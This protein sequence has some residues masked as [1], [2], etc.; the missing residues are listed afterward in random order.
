MP[1]VRSE[2]AALKAL[3]LSQFTQFEE[4][5]AAMAM[6]EV[7]S[8]Q[9]HPLD[10]VTTLVSRD[11]YHTRAQLVAGLAQMA[12]LVRSPAEH[13]MAEVLSHHTSAALG[14][15]AKA[16]IADVIAQAD[17]MLMH[18]DDIA[19]AID[20]HP[21]RVCHALRL[22][23]HDGIFT[24]VDEGTFANN[25]ASMQLLGASPVKQWIL[26]Q[27]WYS[28]GFA[29]KVPD[30]WCDPTKAKSFEQVDSAANA[31]W[32]YSDKGY[33]DFWNWVGQEHLTYAQTFGSALESFGQINTMGVLA[34]YP[35]HSLRAGSVVVDCGGGAGHLLLPILKQHPTLRGVVQDR[36]EIVPAARQNFQSH[37]PQAEVEFDAIDFFKEQ[38]RRQAD[39]YM[40]RWILH[41]WSDERAVALLKQQAAAMGAHSKMIVIDA[42]IAPAMRA[43]PLD[44]SYP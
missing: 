37:L 12:G 18:V 38:P 42:L 17:R 13:L 4:A 10:D 35:W 20:S 3:I 36:A 21:T 39:V 8:T 7:T 2:Y 22:L 44:P 16:G 32:R 43:A 30:T 24:E 41:D 29:S 9:P 6:P 11:L 28:L 31:A 1:D 25:R 40:L 33:D 23:A 5:L 26:F 19:R 34:D 27:S 14:F 15:V